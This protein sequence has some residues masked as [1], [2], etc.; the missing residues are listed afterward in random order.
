MNTC[1]ISTLVV[2]VLLAIA[3]GDLANG[4]ILSSFDPGGNQP[5]AVGYGADEVFVYDDFD[6]VIQVFDRSGAALRTL[7]SPGASSNDYDLDYLD[8]PLTLGGTAVPAG[9][10][11]VANGDDA[12]DTLYAIDKG[13]GLVLASVAVVTNGLV[14]ASYDPATGLVYLVDWVSDL[15]RVIEPT[16]GSGLSSFPIAPAGSPPFDVFYGDVDIDGDGNL[17]VVTDVLEQT[18]VLTTNGDY[19]RDFDLSLISPNTNLD[20]TGIAFDAA[21]GEAWVSSRDGFVYRLEGFPV[22]IPEPAAAWLSLLGIVAAY[23]RGS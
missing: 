6:S 13:N 8:G 5:V 19:I 11:L 16:T 9:S 2:A 17:Q 12:V 7:P 3:F 22:G 1:R 10:L 21:R 23:G 18:R 4:Q 15:I 14:G 20:L